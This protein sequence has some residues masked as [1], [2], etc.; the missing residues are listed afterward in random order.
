LLL[1]PTPLAKVR[2]DLKVRNF[3]NPLR[4][5]FDLATNQETTLSQIKDLTELADRNKLRI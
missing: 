5:I 2:R 1:P 3:D 4:K